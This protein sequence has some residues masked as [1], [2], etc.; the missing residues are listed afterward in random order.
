MAAEEAAHY[1]MIRTETVDQWEYRLKV[2]VSDENLQTEL[3]AAADREY[4]KKEK[5]QRRGM[6]LQQ[7]MWTHG[8]SM[9]RRKGRS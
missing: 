8:G 9:R 1:A 4:A 2:A 7:G 5:Q 3:R 6:V